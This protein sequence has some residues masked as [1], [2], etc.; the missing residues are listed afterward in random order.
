MSTRNNSSP[1]P[2]PPSPVPL[3]DILTEYQ[4]K[5]TQLFKAHCV[6]NSNPG[7]EICM[8]YM[9]SGVCGNGRGGCRFDHPMERFGSGADTNSSPLRM[10]DLLGN[11]CSLCHNVFPEAKGMLTTFVSALVA[12]LDTYFEVLT[13]EYGPGC[14]IY[15]DSVLKVYEAFKT[16]QKSVLP[17]QSKRKK[18]PSNKRGPDTDA[19]FEDTSK[20]ILECLQYLNTRWMEEENL[21]SSVLHCS[22]THPGHP[23]LL[24][25]LE[26]DLWQLATQAQQQQA[27][28]QAR[29]KTLCTFLLSIANSVINTHIL[30][31]HHLRDK[32]SSLLNS[33]ILKPFGSSANTLGTSSSDLDLCLGYDETLNVR[34]A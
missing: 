32:A 14:I 17:T 7:K 8:K 10:I 9:R 2:N 21:Y 6:L 26:R 24:P 1:P 30:E 31:S 27:T 25:G 22:L 16:F 29:K 19:G 4:H 11:V 34:I 15:G 28:H 3:A 5:Y 33:C 13:A 18:G 12:V 20:V 23:Q